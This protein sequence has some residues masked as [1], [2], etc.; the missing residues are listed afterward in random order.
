MKITRHILAAFLLVASLLMPVRS[1]PETVSQK[2]ALN[3]ATRFFN[4]SRSMVMAPPKLVFNGRKLTTGRL[5]SP[6]YVYNHPTG[7]FVI[8]SADNKAYPILGYSL[9]DSFDPNNID[10][11]LNALLRLYAMHIEKIRYDSTLLEKAPEKWIGLPQYID[12]VLNSPYDATDRLTDPAQAREDLLSALEGASGADLYSGIYSPEQWVDLVDAQLAA[13]RNVIMGV[14]IGEDVFPF[15]VQGHRA[16][17]YRINFNGINRGFFRLLP[18][19]VLSTGEAA[20]LKSAPGVKEETIDETFAFHDNFVEEIEAENKARQ[21]AIENALIPDKPVVH[22]YGSGSFRIDL[23]ARP[24]SAIVY[25]VAG[26]IVKSKTFRDSD[27]TF[28]DISEEPAGFYFA[29]IFTEN[30]NS[31]GVKL[32]R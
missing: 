6:F 27:Y 3:I 32:Y 21:S 17:M 4:A 11:D 1:Y 2:E 23:P 30:G 18:T 8:I 26:L 7:G 10:P 9:T 16:D 19:E 20:L 28:I 14:M 13:D 5:F 25:N 12:S 24:V 31:Y 29:I 22:P 15:T